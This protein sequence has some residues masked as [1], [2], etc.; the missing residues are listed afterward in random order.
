MIL[1]CTCESVS[2]DKIHGKSRRVFNKKKDGSFKCATC[3][4]IKQGPKDKG[5]KK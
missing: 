4:T 5:D 1:L 3:G 2:Q